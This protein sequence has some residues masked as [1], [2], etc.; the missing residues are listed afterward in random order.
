MAVTGLRDQDKLDG[1]S[2]F[3]IWKA[4]ILAVLDQNR[5]KNYALKVVAVPVDAD[6]LKKY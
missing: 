2:N 4:R 3:V 5:I 1:A 6:L